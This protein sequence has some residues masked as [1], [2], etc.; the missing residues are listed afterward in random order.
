MTFTKRDEA[1]RIIDND[2]LFEDTDA[3]RQPVRLPYQPDTVLFGGWG[4]RF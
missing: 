4:V 1:R 2:S 3:A